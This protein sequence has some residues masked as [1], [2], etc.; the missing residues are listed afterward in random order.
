MLRQPS[1]ALLEVFSQKHEHVHF[2]WFKE[3]TCGSYYVTSCAE[4]ALRSGT[5]GTNTQVFLG[6]D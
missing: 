6:K 4:D 3:I 2:L 1:V 5:C